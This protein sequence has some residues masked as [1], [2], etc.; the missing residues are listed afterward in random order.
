MMMV[1]VNVLS[2]FDANKVKLQQKRLTLCIVVE[3]VFGE[4]V[5]NQPHL[6]WPMF[7]VINIPLYNTIDYSVIDRHP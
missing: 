1:V 3:T 2:K 6:F 7:V 5:L 4:L